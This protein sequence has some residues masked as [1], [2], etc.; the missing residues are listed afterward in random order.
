LPRLA[1]ERLNVKTDRAE[2]IACLG[3]FLPARGLRGLQFKLS[4]RAMKKLLIVLPLLVGLS[5]PASA[6]AAG[7]LS[8]AVA[9]GIVGHVAGHHGLVGAAVGCAV[10][11]H[12]AEV[13]Q[14][15]AN[16]AEQKNQNNPH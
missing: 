10:G 11:H 3:T 5:L 1:E 2:T 13:K 8:G 14:R 9:G 7:C 4:R 15:Q 16:Q 6:E 12:Q